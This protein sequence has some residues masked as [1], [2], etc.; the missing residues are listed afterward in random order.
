[1]IYYAPRLRCCPV[2][3]KAARRANGWLLRNGLTSIKRV[4]TFLEALFDVDDRGKV[5]G[6]LCFFDEQENGVYISIAWVDGRSRERGIFRQL[7]QAIEHHANTIGSRYI[8][9]EV[10]AKNTRMMEVMSRH[11]D[12]SYVF[13][14][15]RLR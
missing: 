6:I 15:R 11:W 4:D 8:T 7:M 9:T 13:F 2:A 3:L 10:K 12:T 14:T 1:M 5:R